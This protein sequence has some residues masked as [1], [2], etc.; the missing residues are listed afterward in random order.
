MGR[1]GS[2]MPTVGKKNSKA[3]ENTDPS[4]SGDKTF[5]CLSGFQKIVTHLS[6]RVFK[7]HT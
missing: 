3:T 2:C 7:L 4:Y 6:P 1:N 5:V